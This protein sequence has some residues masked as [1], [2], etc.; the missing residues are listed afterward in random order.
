MDIPVI[1]KLLL[2]SP[3]IESQ[4]AVDICSPSGNSYIF[5]HSEPP[6]SNNPS[7]AGNIFGNLTNLS[8]GDIIQ[9]VSTSGHQCQYKVD[10]WDKMVVDSNNDVDINEYYRALQYP[11]KSTES[12]LTIQTCQ[13]GS[14]TVRLLLRASRI[15]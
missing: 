15:S 1:D 9:L 3:V 11:E 10:K 12:S 14:T 7:L 4:D 13:K 5:G 8:S 6:D 2:N